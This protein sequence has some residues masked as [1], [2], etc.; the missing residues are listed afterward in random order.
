M[1][2]NQQY[3]RVVASPQPQCILELEPV[4]WLLEHHAIVIAAG[5]GGIPVAMEASTKK[6]QGIEAVIDKDLCSALLAQAIEADC[7]IIATDVAAIYQNWQQPN[8]TAIREISPQTLRAMTFPKGSMGPKVTAACQF[9]TAT[10]KSAVI[11]S[12][13]EIDSMLQGSSGTWIKDGN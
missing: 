13:E 12:L 8:Q 4:L 11:G 3:R 9:V 1:A 6:Y 5:G 10:K 2:E 7:F